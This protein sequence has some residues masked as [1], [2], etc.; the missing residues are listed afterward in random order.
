MGTPAAS[1]DTLDAAVLEAAASWYVQLHDAAGQSDQHRAWRRW[2][3]SDPRHRQAWARV[4]QLERRLQ[5]VPVE[6]ALPALERVDARR[7]RA[8]KR[9]VVVLAAGGLGG[10]GYR[11]VPWHSW[12]AAYRTAT[13][14]RRSLRLDDG[15]E[16]EL[17]TATA[18]DVAYAPDRRL[19]RLYRGELLIRTGAEAG[20]S[21]RPFDVATAQGR[22]RALGTR[23]LV[24]T[25]AA[26]TRVTVL[27]HAVEV[28]PRSAAAVRVEAGRQLTFSATGCGAPQPAP[29]GA[30]GWTH[31]VLLALD[32]RLAD[33]LAE[34]ARYGSGHLG[35]DPAVA[36]LH[37]SGAFRLDDI[38]GA[39]DN[40]A[41][42]LPVRVNRFTRYWVRIEPR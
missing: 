13:G 33:L 27:E 4:Q 30:D 12:T 15:S 2:L 8:M 24:R 3:D 40:L 10:L 5:S 22:V 34:L 37:V 18:V 42:T 35:C 1:P 28:C 7:R 16:V 26:Q 19:L 36:G 31:G 6:L 29:A 23:F 17:N 41:A 20:R 32:W 39:L 38:P 25:D 11:T 9:L 21:Y 14:Q